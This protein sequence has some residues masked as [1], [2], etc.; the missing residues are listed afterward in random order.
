M[1]GLGFGNA[2]FGGATPGQLVTL[3]NIGGVAMSIAGILTTGD[4]V[5]TN[6]C[7]ATLNTDAS[8]SINVLFAPLRL[9]SRPGELQVYTNADGSP[10]RVLLGGTGCRWF[11]PGRRPVPR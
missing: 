1:T 3:T 9:G 4:Y 7:G 8:C 11:W 5:Q 6:N 2:I 10:H